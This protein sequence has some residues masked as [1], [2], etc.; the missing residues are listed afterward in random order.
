MRPPLSLAEIGFGRPVTTSEPR[1]RPRQNRFASVHLENWRNFLHVQS[2]LQRRA[3]LIGPNASGKSNFLDVFRFLHDL[4]AV[5]GGFQQAVRKRGG[6]SRLRSLAARR[7]PDIVVRVTL[8]SNGD[9]AADWVYELS[10]TQDNRQRPVIR[11]EKVSRGDNEILVRPL[12]EDQK[13][14]ER[15]TQTYLE[16]VNVNRDFREIAEFFA[17]VRYLH[18]VPQLVR[19]PDRSVGRKNDPFGGDFLEQVATTQEKVQKARFRRIVEA[20]KVAVPQLS[21]LELYRDV[22]G[23]PHLRGKY[24]HWR[25]Q[26]A[27]QTED[28]FSD[29]TLRLLGL[30][31]AVLD[32]TGPL[33]LEEPELSLHPEV[34]RVFP[35]MMARIQRRFGRQIL[36]STHS[37]DV[38]RDSGIGLDEVLVL[39]PG[40]EGTEVRRA[41]DY[42]EVKDLLDG[43]MTL[44][45]ALIPRTRPQNAE[46]L[47]L[48]ADL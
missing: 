24:A 20:L 10:F 12:P 19:E 1:G 40:V 36:L 11:R 8:N 48:F 34:V 16:Q 9:S 13:D 23:T 44:A 27:W 2:D 5:G 37:P 26:G 28:Q 43:G 18:I 6:V 45:E 3:F 22:R 25:A 29:G 30:L 39:V 35:Q 47:S 42:A 31:W 21:G 38:L 32:G 41:T 17:S 4:A 15:L 33:L 46:Q 14:P 7:Y